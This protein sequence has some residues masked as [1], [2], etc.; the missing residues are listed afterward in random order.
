MDSALEL[1]L[2]LFILSVLAL[3]SILAFRNHHPLRVPILG[4]T[5]LL[6]PLGWLAAWYMYVIFPRTPFTATGLEPS[7]AAD[8]ACPSCGRFYDPRDYRADAD[9]MLC[10]YCGAE[11]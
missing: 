11:L 1:F 6:G 2:L 7:S 5:I 4:V 8:R 3:P 10:S 9:Q